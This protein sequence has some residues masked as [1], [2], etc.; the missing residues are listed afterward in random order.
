MN[1]FANS[2]S[3]YCAMPSTP[4]PKAETFGLPPRNPVLRL[5]RAASLR[6]DRCNPP[7]SWITI[8][9]ADNGPGVPED[10]GDRIFEP[11]VSTK[12]TGIGLGLAI[13]RRIVQSH[14]GEITASNAPEGGAVFTV[15][16]PTSVLSDQHCA[17]ATVKLL[18]R[19]R[20]CHVQFAD[21]RRRAECVL[22]AAKGARIPDAQD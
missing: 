19:W 18:S 15:R 22:L 14:G 1:N 3:I 16:L 4:C 2:F 21:N 17:E 20:E 11:Y 8:T 6:A 10:L 13:C 12:D 5:S 7:V 9:I